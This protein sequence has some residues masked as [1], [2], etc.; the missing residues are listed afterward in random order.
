MK[1]TARVLLVD[2]EPTLR[3][4]IADRLARHY[5]VELASSGEEGLQQLSRRFFDLVVTDA[6]VPDMKAPEVIAEARRR[7]P[8]TK[9]ALITGDSMKECIRFAIDNDVGTIITKTIPFDLDELL[10]IVKGILT[11]DVFGLEKYLLPDAALTEYPV[12]QSSHISRVRDRILQQPAIR[13]WPDQRKYLLRLALDES[14]S[15]AAYHGNQIPKGAPYSFSKDQEVRVVYGEDREKIGV[16]VADQAG[17][18]DKQ[19]ILGKLNS[20]MTRDDESLFQDSGRGL[21]LIL[22]VVHR[23]IV[24]IRKG[25]RTEIIMIFWPDRKEIGH[26]PIIINEL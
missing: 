24:N 15:N 3:G 23:L 11:E 10:K 21:F 4:L 1:T 5:E 14:I 17:R 7:Y 18:L 12:R 9:T 22:S 13:S 2:D 26:R 20:C 8:N 16:A 6:N 19:T 25:Y